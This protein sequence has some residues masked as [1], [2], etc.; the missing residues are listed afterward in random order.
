MPKIERV[1]SDT[2]KKSTFTLLTVLY[3]TLFTFNNRPPRTSCYFS[4]YKYYKLDCRL[5]LR[6]THNDT[7]NV[8]PMS[9][10]E[11]IVRIHPQAPSPGL[12]SS[13]SSVN[14][15]KIQNNY[16]CFCGLVPPLPRYIL[17]KSRS[18]IKAKIKEAKMLKSFFFRRELVA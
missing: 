1:L 8:R 5:T 18:K 15:K 3:G 11:N 17:V 6:Q 14:H 9:S 7:G 16:M 2:C 13:W 4:V 10:Q 12:S